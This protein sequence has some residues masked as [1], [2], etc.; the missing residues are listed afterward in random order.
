[1]KQTITFSGVGAHHQN[2]I[3]ERAIQTISNMARAN[4]V[5]AT[6]HWPDHSFISLWPL[7]MNYAIW[8]YNQIPPSG[9]GWSPEELWSRTKTPHSGLPCAHVFGCPVYVLDPKL[10]DGKKI[11]K[12]KS[13]ARQGNWIGFSLLHSST[14]PLVLNP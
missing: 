9:A 8:I 11:P 6:L 12:W 3:A 1:M 7:V 2:G 13:G 14:V 10:Q 4:M 5:H